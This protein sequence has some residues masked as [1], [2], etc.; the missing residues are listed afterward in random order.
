MRRGTAR[1]SFDAIVGRLQRDRLP[2]VPILATSNSGAG[3]SRIS[4]AIERAGANRS[5]PISTDEHRP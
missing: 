4:R 5:A 1:P 2:F 3:H